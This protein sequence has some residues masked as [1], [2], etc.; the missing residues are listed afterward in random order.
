M[1]HGGYNGTCCPPWK[2]LRPEWLWLDHS[3]ETEG[4]W[5]VKPGLPHARSQDKSITTEHQRNCPMTWKKGGKSTQPLESWVCPISCAS[6]C[7]L[8]QMQKSTSTKGAS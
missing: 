5:H 8:L 1:S 7:R 6:S 4:S 2:P 3:R